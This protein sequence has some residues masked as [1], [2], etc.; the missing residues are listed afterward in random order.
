MEA[1]ALGMNPAEKCKMEALDD[2]LIGK[3][4][5]LNPVERNAENNKFEGVDIFTNEERRMIFIILN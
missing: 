5:L 1:S 2:R 3:T 4:I